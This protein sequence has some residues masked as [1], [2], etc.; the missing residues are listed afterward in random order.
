MKLDTR[1]KPE[2]DERRQT[3]LPKGVILG[4]DPSIHGLA[5]LILPKKFTPETELPRYP[6]HLFG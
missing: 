2:Y 5:V 3:R 1:V 6:V 4:L